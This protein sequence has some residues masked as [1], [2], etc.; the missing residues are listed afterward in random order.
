[1][2]KL[3]V[4]M[5]VLGAVVLGGCAAF[6]VKNPTT[7]KGYR[8]CQTDLNCTLPERCWFV[9]PDTFAVCMVP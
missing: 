3:I 5:V 8:N 2:K 6:E 9:R 4:S 1:M 7:P